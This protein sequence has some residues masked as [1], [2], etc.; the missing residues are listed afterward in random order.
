MTPIGR[1]AEQSDPWGSFEPYVQL[2]R[3]L[4]P[5]AT[6]VAIFDAG[7]DMRW[8]NETTTGPDLANLVEDALPNARKSKDSA[9]E[10]RVLGGSVPV[11]IC[12]LRND[13]GALLAIVAVLSRANGATEADSRGFSLAYALLRPALECLRRDLL[14]RAAIDDLS[15]SVSSLDKDLELLL[16]DSVAARTAAG[17]DGADELKSIVQQAMEHLKCATAAL[18]VP[19]KGIV[20]MRAASG[21]MPADNQLVARTHRQLLSM[22]Q[23]RREPVIM[24]RLSPGSGAPRIPYR[25]LSCPL[26]QHGGKTIGVL[27][28]FR[29]DSSP[30]FTARDARICDILARKANGVIESN[31]DAM[32]GLY[33][34]PAFEQRVRAVVAARKRPMLWSALYI[35]T[36]QLHVIND[37]FGMHVGDAI[38]GQLGELIRRRLAPGAFAARISGDRFAVLLPTG[39]DDAAQFAESLREGTELLG[40]M[41]GEARMHVSIS[42]GVAS[43][44]TESGELMHSLAAA[45]TA[46]KAAKDRGRNRVETYQADDASIVRRFADIN[47]AARLRVAISEDRLR[48]D[49]QLIMP[50]TTGP[51]L[52]PHYELL[53]RMIDEDGK[54]LGPDRFLSAANRYQLMPTIDRWVIDKAIALLKPQAE[55]LAGHPVGFAINFSGQSLNDAHFGDFLLERIES[56]GLD[57]ALFCFELT[58]NA[59][60]ANIGRAEVLMRRL[61]G[62]GCNIALDDF[63][64]GLSSLSYLRQLPVTTLK[65][66]GSFVRDILKDARSESMVRAIAQLARSMSIATV[67]EYV[68]TDEI[69]QRI[70]ALGVDY[71]QGFAIGRPTPFTNVLAELPL[72]AAAAPVTCAADEEVLGMRAANL[73]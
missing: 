21:Q 26:Q 16:T 6:S 44:D 5:R 14:A 56:S 17:S 60:V 24:N 59:T 53:L 27:A 57:P 55:L 25:I 73:H 68:E 72:L 7:G 1:S 19:E 33:T 8:T 46:C 71:G 38:I 43:L 62:L 4:L 70:A 22:A 51:N 50:F 66:D 28:L 48:L 10:M 23:M 39:L 52:R 61:R 12:W 2:I 67:A 65:I 69:R 36:D 58:E 47:I 54:M 49:A 41:H 20:L 3:S 15:R 42:I 13:A 32:S 40:A 45:E 9:G 35:D 63:G 37:N 11:Y 34:R 64:T 29:E 18:I 30:K 31:Y